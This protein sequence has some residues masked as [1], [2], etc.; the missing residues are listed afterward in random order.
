MTETHKSVLASF[1]VALVGVT[2]VL[3]VVTAIVEQPLVMLLLPVAAAI[4][5][6]TAVSFLRDSEDRA[7][8]LP[9]VAD[10]IPFYECAAGIQMCDAQWQAHQRA[11][12]DPK[13][14]LIRETTFTPA[15]YWCGC[16]KAVDTQTFDGSTTPKGPFYLMALYIHADSEHL[17]VWDPQRRE[18]VRS[19]YDLAPKMGSRERS[20]VTTYPPHA[21]TTRRPDNRTVVRYDKTDGRFVS[22]DIPYHGSTILAKV[23]PPDPDNWELESTGWND[24]SIHNGHMYVF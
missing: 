15:P 8:A 10:R 20:D 17:M 9:A 5:Y 19:M 24:H 14:P 2:T 18:W 13:G 7:R 4:F 22:L 12:T 23:G 21:N 6:M 11:L 1:V 16:Q 3:L